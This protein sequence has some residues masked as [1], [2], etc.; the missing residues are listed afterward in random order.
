MS[1]HESRHRAR[2]ADL[3]SKLITISEAI[4][5]LPGRRKAH[6]LAAVEGDRE[7]ITAIEQIDTEGTDLQRQLQLTSAA[8]EECERLDHL[9]QSKESAIEKARREA[10]AKKKI[11]S[12]LITINLETDAALT[13]LR[14]MLECREHTINELRAA[15]GIDARMAFRL[16]SRETIN[17]ALH[18]SKWNLHVSLEQCAPQNRRGLSDANRILP[19]L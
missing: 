6:A 18:A 19:H 17:A 13:Q 14:E 15:G 1:D 10:E 5:M 2:I 9:H 16:T 7:A 3:Q 4:A 8:L 11:G 12:A